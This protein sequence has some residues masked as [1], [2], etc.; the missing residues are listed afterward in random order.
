MG[1][2][3]VAQIDI[4]DRDR[5][6]QYEAGFMDVFAQYGGE[7]LAVDEAPAV[8]EGRWSCTRTVLIRFADDTAA[9]AWYDSE[10]YQELA[11]HRWAASAA[12]IALLHGVPASSGR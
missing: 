10:A 5:Y 1:V 2:F 7:I 9:R 3:V 12:D 6:A 8:L 4:H 11:H